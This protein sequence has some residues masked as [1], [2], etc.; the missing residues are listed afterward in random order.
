M[1]RFRAKGVS[2][3]S[4]KLKGIKAQLVTKQLMGEI[5]SDIRA[6]IDDRTSKGKDFTGR[7]FSPYS[8]SYLKRKKARAGDL[9][10][11]RVDLNDTGKMQA[12]INHKAEKSRVTIGFNDPLSNAKASGH[13]RG[14]KI[15]PK[16]TFFKLGRLGN[17]ALMNEVER[18]IKKV[19]S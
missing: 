16:R 10:S 13:N 15:L 5:G 14:S 8:T 7:S 9:F 3:L 6:A 1:I 17:I 2:E 4:T 12:A 18:H 11:G 19:I